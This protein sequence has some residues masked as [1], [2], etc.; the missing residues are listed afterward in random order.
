MVNIFFNI[1]LLST[2]YK[3]EA[4]PPDGT[5]YK[6]LMRI[7][8]YNENEDKAKQ[9]AVWLCNKLFSTKKCVIKDCK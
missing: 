8:S 9:E 5:K 1:I 4:V 2:I 7:Y 3:C 6:G